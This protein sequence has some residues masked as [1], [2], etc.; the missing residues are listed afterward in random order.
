MSANL[1]DQL[2]V[3]ALV[4]KPV[5]Y[6]ENYWGQALRTDPRNKN[7][8]LEMSFWPKFGRDQMNL[9]SLP[10]S[11]APRLLKRPLD[12]ML[13]TFTALECSKPCW[14]E[15]LAQSGPWYL[16]HWQIWDNAPFLPTNGDVTKDPRYGVNT[17][18]FTKP[19]KISTT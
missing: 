12:R 8:D 7:F 2:Q 1:Q 4:Q 17:R 13:P 19:Q 10:Y 9:G 14:N 3:Q 18:Q 16:R 15:A 6:I 11:T 5:K